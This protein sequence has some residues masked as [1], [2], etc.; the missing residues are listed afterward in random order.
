LRFIIKSATLEREFKNK[1][2]KVRK[3][4]KISVLWLIC[5][6][7][8]VSVVPM[9]GCGDTE[10]KD[11]P[12]AADAKTS[13][14]EAPTPV[15]L[16]AQNQNPTVPVS[17]KINGW[18]I[19]M[20]EDVKK[21]IEVTHEKIK[22]AQGQ[23]AVRM[24]ISN[25]SDKPVRGPSSTA[26]YDII[27]LRV[28]SLNGNGEPLNKDN[29]ATVYFSL[30]AWEKTNPLAVV[31]YNSDR[32][33]GYGLT[34]EYKPIPDIPGKLVPDDRGWLGSRISVSYRA[35]YKEKGFPDGYL[36]T[37]KITNLTN[38][39]LRGESKGPGSLGGLTLELVAKDQNGKQINT[40]YLGD[41]QQ[42]IFNL[43]S[44]LAPRSERNFT[45]KILPDFGHNLDQVKSYDLV[46]V[47]AK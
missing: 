36:I 4:K 30:G 11:N 12:P 18:L 39:E 5:L 27:I 15:N 24:V 6:V 33:A 19:P 41:R 46:L 16:P 38:E 14:V 29:P 9:A 44:V 20:P 47:F 10:A 2:R 43:A 26:K 32:T 21:M 42:I 13:K 17:G 34:A 25:I 31:L 28:F 23:N 40:G 7:L 8:I 1:R 22:D 3:V 37:G 35:E 45:F